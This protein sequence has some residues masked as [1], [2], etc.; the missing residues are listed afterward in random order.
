MQ[1][2]EAF[3]IN[4]MVRELLNPGT[5]RTYS[6]CQPLPAEILPEGFFL[7]ADYGSGLTPSTRYTDIPYGPDSFMVVLDSFIISDNVQCNY[8]QVMDTG[9]LYS[10]HNPVV[11]RFELQQLS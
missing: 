9:F 7:C 6:W 1:N 5:D 4:S 3:C 10:D 11:L 2:A 8:T